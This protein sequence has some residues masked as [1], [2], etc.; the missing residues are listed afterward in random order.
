MKNLECSSQCNH[1]CEQFCL[2][3]LSYNNALHLFLCAENNYYDNRDTMPTMDGLSP[4]LISEEYCQVQYHTNESIIDS[5]FSSLL[6]AVPKKRRSLER[7][8][9]RRN[10]MAG[11]FE[12]AVPRRD[13]VYDEDSDSYKEQGTVCRKHFIGCIASRH[14]FNIYC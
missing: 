6:L 4:L 8:M 2:S 9:T 10:Q 5:I 1:K 12:Y 14:L 11:H 7:R 13:I 3:I